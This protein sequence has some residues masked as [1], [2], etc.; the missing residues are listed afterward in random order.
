M[1]VRWRVLY[2]KLEQP[3]IG[4]HLL[5]PWYIIGVDVANLG[6]GWLNELGRWI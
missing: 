1:L 4:E 2:E 6:P 5:S 3:T